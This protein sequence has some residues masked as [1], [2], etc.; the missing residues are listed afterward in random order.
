VGRA[1]SRP[2]TLRSIDDLW[3]F[4]A[5]DVEDIRRDIEENP[6]FGTYQGVVTDLAPREPQRLYFSG[7][8]TGK[9]RPTLYTQWDRE[10]SALF[11]A[12]ALYR[13]GVRPG[14]VV[15]NSYQYSTFN[16]GALFDEAAH[17]WLNCVVISTSSGNVT[18]SEKQV[19]LAADYAAT[20]IMTT[21][22]HLMRIIEV[23]RELG[24]DPLVDLN[25]RAVSGLG[26]ER[27]PRR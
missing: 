13:Q 22:D 7:G 8:T 5:Y 21:G 6:P 1:E 17:H 12:R 27:A 20:C 26:I 19:Q 18:P 9:V 11:M 2:D 3:K 25:I 10:V 14:D 24:Y 4:P 23:A 15:L 16:G